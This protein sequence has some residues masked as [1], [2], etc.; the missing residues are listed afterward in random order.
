LEGGYSAESAW[1]GWMSWEGRVEKRGCEVRPRY[2]SYFG[3]KTVTIN[4][5]WIN[6]LQWES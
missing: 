5:L 3:E 2:G 6:A 4:A 1:L